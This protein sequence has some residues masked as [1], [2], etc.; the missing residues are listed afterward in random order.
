MIV[1]YV[2]DIVPRS[3]SI[4]L[5]IFYGVKYNIEKGHYCLCSSRFLYY[6][7]VLSMRKVILQEDCSFA[8]GDSGIGVQIKIQVV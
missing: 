4:K 6:Y 7:S 5:L 2:P 8:G 1:I 3:L